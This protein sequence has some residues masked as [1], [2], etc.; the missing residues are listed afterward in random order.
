MNAILEIK[1][2]HKSFEGLSLFNDASWQIPKGAISV[3]LGKNGSGKTTL[4]NMLTGYLKP[5]AG[6]VLFE[7]KPLGRTSPDGV[8]RLGIGKMWQSPRTMLFLNH[9]VLDNLMVAAPKH[10]GDR[11]LNNFFSYSAVKQQEANIKQKAVGLLEEL[12]LEQY[13]QQPAGALSLGNQKMVCLGMLLMSEARLLLLD[14]PFSSIHP[15][16]IQKISAVLLEQKQAGK[17]I[18][19]IEHKINFA[20]QISDYLFE[21]QNQKIEGYETI[22]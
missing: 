16:T 17:S 6:T 18:L 15:D 13:T 22:F 3:L 10:K 11:L 7:E 20:R 12:E 19:M 5:D 21:I 4:F 9:S 1:H 2:L 8:A 14:E